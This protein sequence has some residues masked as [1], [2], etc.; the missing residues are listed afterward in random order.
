M[1][2]RL[3]LLACTG[4]CIAAM[5]SAA[6]NGQSSKAA[7]VTVRGGVHSFATLPQSGVPG[8]PL[9]HPEGLC[10]D[11]EGNVYANTFDF[12]AQN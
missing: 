12:G 4:V 5:A 3:A 7:D 6:G 9:G 11:A 10:A 8:A 1:G 2:K